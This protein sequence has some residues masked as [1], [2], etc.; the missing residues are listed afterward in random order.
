MKN[1]IFLLTFILSST[2]A[3]AQFTDSIQ[4]ITKKEYVP[5][6]RISFNHNKIMAS[7]QWKEIL[8]NVKLRKEKCTIIDEEGSFKTDCY[9]LGIGKTQ[10]G[11]TLNVIRIFDNTLTFDYYPK[12]FV[13]GNYEAL[14]EYFPITYKYVFME[15]LKKNPNA[16]SYFFVVAVESTKDAYPNGMGYMT[17][18]IDIDLKTKKIKS[19]EFFDQ[20][21]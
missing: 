13:G 21:Q 15:Y 8:K 9:F 14:R 3:N 2:V 19:F 5:F 6:E 11:G 7:L 12:M 10:L 18:G 4:I 20:D 17:M 16:K 1:I